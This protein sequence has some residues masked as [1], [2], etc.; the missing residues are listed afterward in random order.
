METVH[1]PDQNPLSI[2]GKISAFSILRRWIMNYE[3]FE[4]PEKKNF[5]I[6]MRKELDPFFSE[7]TKGGLEKYFKLNKKV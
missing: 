4:H 7:L 3:L 1:H 6:D 5:L 2:G